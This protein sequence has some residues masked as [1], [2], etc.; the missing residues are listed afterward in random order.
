MKKERGG[1]LKIG[2]TVDYI[3]SSWDLI[4][5][6]VFVIY[7]FFRI[8]GNYI[9]LLLLLLHSFNS[10]PPLSLSHTHKSFS[11]DE[12]KVWRMKKMCDRI[13]LA[14]CMPHDDITP[15]GGTAE[16]GGIPGVKHTKIRPPFHLLQPFF[17]W[18]VHARNLVHSF[19]LKIFILNCLKVRSK[20]CIFYFVLSSIIHQCDGS[21]EKMK[22]LGGF[23]H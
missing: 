18:H 20:L 5:I 11:L 1:K 3:P 6:C 12:E 7:V 10:L 19:A 9:F 13:C 14:P 16:S 2:L 4:F 8:H 21:I 22:T 15:H 23:V 17:K